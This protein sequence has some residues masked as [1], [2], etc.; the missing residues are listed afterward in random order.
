MIQFNMYAGGHEVLPYNPRFQI[1]GKISFHRYVGADLVSARG[2]NLN[3]F[4]AFMRI[5]V[6][7]GRTRGPPLQT[8]IS[9]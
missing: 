9:D 4:V 6:I 1:H 2:F 5:V 7:S 8:E 3:Y